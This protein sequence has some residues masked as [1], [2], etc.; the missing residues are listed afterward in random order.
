MK[1]QSAVF[2][3]IGTMLLFAADSSAQRVTTYY[4]RDVTLVQ[5]KTYSWQD[6]ST[7]DPLDVDRI[8][9]AVNAALAA[10]GWTQ[11]NSGAEVSI[12][13]VEMTRTE[14]M[15]VDYSRPSAGMGWEP[16]PGAPE[17]TE[18]YTKGTL[19]VDLFDA[20]TKHLVWRGSLSETLSDNSDKREKNLDKGVKKMLMGL[21]ATAE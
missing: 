6:V 4:D 2:A 9:N 8:K 15:H 16:G 17:N 14:Q 7:K 3:L 19:I 13:A 18:T 10:K 20:K 11:V 5:Y 12:L 21:P 1:W